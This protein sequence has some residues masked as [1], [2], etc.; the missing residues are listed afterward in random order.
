MIVREL[1]AKLGLEL[2]EVG[3]ERG[4]EAIHKLHLGFVAFGTAA[5]GALAIGAA[6]L[7][8]STADAAASAN[9]LALSTGTNLKDVQ[10]LG[11]AAESTGVDIETLAHGLQRLAKGG[12]KDVRGEFLKLAE[13]MHE[14]PNDGRRVQLAIEKFGRGAGPQLVPL[15]AKGKEGIEELMQEA[16]E[17]GLVFNEQDVVAG[18]EFKKQLHLLEGA[19]KGFGYTIGRIVLPFFTKL[20][21]AMAQFALALRKGTM[22]TNDLAQSLKVLAIIAGG[23][24]LA[25][26]VA[27]A[28]ALAVAVA[29][30]IA[31][32]A[33]AVASALSAAL[34]WA[35]AALPVVL[36]TAAFVILG[37]VIEDI[38]KYLTGGDS[39]LGRI[40]DKAALFLLTITAAHPGDP[41]WLNDLREALRIATGLE[42]I[43]TPLMRGALGSLHAT[44]SAL[45]QGNYGQALTAPITGLVSGL[46]DNDTDAQIRSAAGNAT[47]AVSR[48]FAPQVT[49]QVS[50]NADP[51]EIASKSVAQIAAFHAAEMR[52]AAHGVE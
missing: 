10:E 50:T 38:Y 13:R 47:S 7:A 36:L 18:K 9:K 27:N 34:A 25:A 39:L 15:L 28:E 2:D 33:A 24:L 11:F 32:G 30:Y 40:M 23:V 52:K 31:A 19:V 5:V 3:F 22:W 29:G 17:L 45:A 8:K 48:Y 42:S 4:E 26:L 6:Y 16:E 35:A 46:Q 20:V 21:K 12:A 43:L 14:M 44:T 41:W 49:V 37:L 51:N 1:F